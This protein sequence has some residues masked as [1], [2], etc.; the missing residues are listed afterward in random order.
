M[1]GNLLVS[2]CIFEVYLVD[3]VREVTID[4]QDAGE[5]ACSSDM[6]KLHVMFL[7]GT[8]DV[9]SDMPDSY[10]NTYVCNPQWGLRAHAHRIKTG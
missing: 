5:V 6:L 2:P 1:T 3:I 4:Q 7:Q 8:C 9:V 10:C